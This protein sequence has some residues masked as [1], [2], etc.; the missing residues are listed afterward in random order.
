MVGNE[1]A[2]AENVALILTVCEAPGWSVKVDGEK[3]TPT[4]IP[5]KETAIG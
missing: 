1:F 4:G 2:A 5:A 3:V